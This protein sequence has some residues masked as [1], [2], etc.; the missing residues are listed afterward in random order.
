MKTILPLFFG[1]TAFASSLEAQQITSEFAASY[2]ITSFNSPWGEIGHAPLDLAFPGSSV[3]RTALGAGQSSAELHDYLMIRT[4]PGNGHLIGYN[5][6][7]TDR[8]AIAPYIAN[9]M[10]L[11]AGGFLAYTTPQG[12]V[13]ITDGRTSIA[14]FSF[15][16]LD[17]SGGTLTLTPPLIGRSDDLT[18][19]SG[20]G[21]F[22]LGTLSGNSLDS[23][24]LSIT[25]PGI[26]LVD[27]PVGVAYITNPVRY[28]QEP[29]LL[30]LD[31][32]AFG[33]LSVFTLD[34][35]GLPIASSKRD[36]A[37]GIPDAFGLAIDTITGD[38]LVSGNN[39]S[40]IYEIQGFTSVPEPN[41]CGI[42]ALAL[43]SLALVWRNRL[44]QEQTS[45]R[46]I[47]SRSNQ[48]RQ[49]R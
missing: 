29:S 28:V 44:Q 7:H 10:T 8:F 47:G 41:C 35:S 4:A 31:G 20:S 30:V 6:G 45:P 33:T 40:S 15:P 22:L 18:L 13:G 48:D 17:A 9:G 34:A 24:A 39:G 25:D 14:T 2:S 21:M 43:L 19:L 5:E 1:L 37:T 42:A 23:F 12:S 27:H 32:G 46:V 3:L 36:L 38:V 11:L 49:A 26:H 16:Q